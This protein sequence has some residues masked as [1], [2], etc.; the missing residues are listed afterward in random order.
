MLL[1]SLH[2][3]FNPNST[4]FVLRSFSEGE[5]NQLNM[6][7]IL[8]LLIIAFLLPSAIISQDKKLT[9]E[10]ASYMNRSIM[11]KSISGLKWMG[12]TAL[13]SFNEDNEVMASKA[14]TAKPFRLFGLDDINSSL[15]KLEEDTLRRLP[16]FRWLDDNSAYF[17]AGNKV[18]FYNISSKQ[19]RELN[20]YPEE[21]ANTDLDENTYAMAYTIENNLYIAFEGR[22]IQITHDDAP[23]IINGQTV[24]RSEFGLSL[25]HI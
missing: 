6:K 8:L 20:D 4:N 17:T 21:A 19:I 12:S 23:E 7:N 2:I 18:Y 3:H 25:I 13:F 15:K 24:H 5:F 1:L 9:I 10:D 22:Q 11:P 16:S 14:T